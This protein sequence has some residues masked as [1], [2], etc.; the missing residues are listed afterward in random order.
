MCPPEK[1]PSYGHDLQE[2]FHISK[3]WG[4]GVDNQR[5]DAG[6]IEEDPN[7]CCVRVR[8]SFGNSPDT[9]L[10]VLFFFLVRDMEIAGQRATLRSV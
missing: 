6:H 7:T 2:E 1:M 8:F 3:L 10:C 4:H 5:N 9:T